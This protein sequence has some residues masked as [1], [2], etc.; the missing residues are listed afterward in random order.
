MCT[1]EITF[2]KKIWQMTC[3]TQV[4]KTASTICESVLHAYLA[5]EQYK[6]CE[7]MTVCVISNFSNLF[8][9][10]SIKSDFQWKLNGDESPTLDDALQTIEFRKQFRR[11]VTNNR[12]TKWN[13]GVYKWN[14]SLPYD[15][16]VI[17]IDWKAFNQWQGTTT[18]LI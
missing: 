1:E 18:P 9:T 4:Y 10:A 14:V 7:R 5:H 17:A 15:A 11:D 16:A 8:D 13:S 6:R 3:R 2:R 12:P